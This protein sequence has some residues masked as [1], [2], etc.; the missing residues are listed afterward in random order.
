MTAL[1]PWVQSTFRIRRIICIGATYCYS[2]TKELGWTDNAIGLHETGLEN[3]MICW[4]LSSTAMTRPNAH[5][6]GILFR[7]RQRNRSM[8]ESTVHRFKCNVVSLFF[9]L[10]FALPSQDILLA[11]GWTALQGTSLTLTGCIIHGYGV[12]LYLADEGM[13]TG[14]S[15]TL[16]IESRLIFTGYC[17]VVFTPAELTYSLVPTGLLCKAMRSIDKA[18][19]ISR[20]RN[21]QFPA[22]YLGLWCWGVLGSLLPTIYWS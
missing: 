12:F 7:G 16:E 19:A 8:N 6:P 4:L 17:Y 15:W 18:W 2:T 11:L 5:C 21:L 1:P 10:G 9:C 3:T 22:E 13:P 14:A 20:Q